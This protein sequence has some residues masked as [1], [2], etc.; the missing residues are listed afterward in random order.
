MLVSILTNILTFRFLASFISIF[1]GV[2]FIKSEVSVNQKKLSRF[3][4]LVYGLLFI[5]IGIMNFLGK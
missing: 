4:S 5:V 2:C 3:F 1:M